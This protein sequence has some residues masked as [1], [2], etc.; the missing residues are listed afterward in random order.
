VFRSDVALSEKE[1]EEVML[2]IKLWSLQRVS[3][4]RGRHWDSSNDYHEHRT[5]RQLF[6]Y[7]FRYA[8]TSFVDNLKVSTYSTGSRRCSILGLIIG[9]R[10]VLRPQRAHQNR[11]VKLSIDEPQELGIDIVCVEPH[12]VF[13]FVSRRRSNGPPIASTVHN[14]SLRS[15]GAEIA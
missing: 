8:A 4:F 7:S 6:R 3:G 13:S 12:Y 2:L 14:I 15:N 9:M 11:I 10:R 5:T 1:V